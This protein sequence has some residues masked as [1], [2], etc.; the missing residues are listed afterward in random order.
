[1][2]RDLCEKNGFSFICND[3]ITTNY[4]WNN[5]VHL[6]DMGTHILSNHF[7]KFLNNSI[8]LIDLRKRFLYNPLIGYIN[9]NSLKEKVIPLREVLSNV[10]IDV[11]CVDETKLESSFLDHQFKIEGY[12]FP[13]FRRDRNSKGGGKLVYLWE[14]FLAERIPKFETEKAETICIEITIAKKKWCILFAYRPPNF[15]K[16]E[17]F[18]EISVTLYKALNKYDNL[19]LAGDLNI[20][21]LRPTSDSSN[22]LS[23]LND[24]FSL[25]NLVTDSTCFKSNKDTLIDLMLTNK[26]KSFYKSHSFVTGLSDCHKLIVSILRS[27]HPSL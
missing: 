5:D 18:E 3:V 19:L 23:D 12:Q 15:S 11:L 14:G 22:H 24:T 2:L 27:F 10:P 20:N 6:Q 9:I 16:T 7:F 13:P 17:F 25:T 1:M 8:E 26:P 21:T 4:L